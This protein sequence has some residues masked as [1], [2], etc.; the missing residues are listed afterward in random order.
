MSGFPAVLRSK[1]INSPVFKKCFHEERTMPVVRKADRPQLREDLLF[2]SFGGIIFLRAYRVNSA[3]RQIGICGGKTGHRTTL[4]FR[5]SPQTGVGI[6]I[7][8]RAAHRHTGVLTC[9]FPKFIHE[10]WCFYPGDCHTSDIG[11]WFAMTGS[12]I[13]H[14]SARQIPI[15]LSASR[16]PVHILFFTQILHRFCLFSMDFTKP[17]GYYTRVRSKKEKTQ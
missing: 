12:S 13:P 8:I 9:H 7:E 2:L 4:S 5:T 17:P 14:P 1:S 10:K 3:K 6:S 16:K 15:S 11:H